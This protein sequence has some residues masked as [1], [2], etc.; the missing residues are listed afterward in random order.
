MRLGKSGP[1]KRLAKLGSSKSSP[2]QKTKASL[3]IQISAGSGFQGTS[4]DSPA[5]Y[6]LGI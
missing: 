6:S 1:Q 4:Y 2:G 5:A 3:A